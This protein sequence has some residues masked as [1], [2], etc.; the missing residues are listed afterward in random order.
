MVAGATQRPSPQRPHC[1]AS[2]SIRRGGNP[3]DHLNPHF[4][5]GETEAASRSDLCKVRKEQSRLGRANTRN[6][7]PSQ[8]SHI[9][10][11]SSLGARIQYSRSAVGDEL[12]QLVQ[13]DLALHG[14]CLCQCAHVQSDDMFGQHLGG[15]GDTGSACRSSQAWV[16]VHRSS[17]QA[18]QSWQGYSEQKGGGPLS[19]GTSAAKSKSQSRQG[20]LC[21][22]RGAA[23]ENKSL[24]REAEQAT[25]DR[26]GHDDTETHT[27][28]GLRDISHQVPPGNSPTRAAWG[29]ITR[30]QMSPKCQL[31]ISCGRDR[32]PGGE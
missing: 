4:G 27:Q 9:G 20:L 8:A 17:K 26:K 29:S 14:L 30:T 11:L 28:L 2:L 16:P 22:W 6:G 10:V 3:R 5:D 21:N 24:S 18:G 25:R 23:A 15:E 32:G 12:L 13:V 19:L 7:A 1:S 31:R